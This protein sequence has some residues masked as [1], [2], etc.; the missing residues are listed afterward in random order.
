[1]RRCIAGLPGE[2]CRMERTFV[3]SGSFQ[4]SFV[5]V[6]QLHIVQAE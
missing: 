5:I 3:D 4:P 1:M 6:G 2:E